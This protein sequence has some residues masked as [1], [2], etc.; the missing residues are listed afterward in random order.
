MLAYLSDLIISKNGFIYSS[1]LLSLSA[2]FVFTEPPLYVASPWLI[3]AK[4]AEKDEE[5]CSYLCDYK[6][7]DVDDDD[8]D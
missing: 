8:D 3:E 6:D 2:V 5:G 4:P 7:D 1:C